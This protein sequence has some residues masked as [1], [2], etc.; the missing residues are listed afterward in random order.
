[1]EFANAV[2][3]MGSKCPFAE[4]RAILTAETM[5]SKGVWTQDDVA[6]KLVLPSQSLGNQNNLTF[7]VATSAT[8]M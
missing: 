4:S 6:F 2:D 7:I 5:V 1:M 8:R 3:L